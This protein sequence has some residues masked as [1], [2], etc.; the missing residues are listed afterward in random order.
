MRPLRP[1]CF[2]AGSRHLDRLFVFGGTL[3]PVQRTLAGAIEEGR[4]QHKASRG[5]APTE[6][7]IVK[8]LE[9]GRDSKCK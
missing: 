2:L 1:C 3:A 5:P 8:R 6:Q 7:Q 4:S 9:Q